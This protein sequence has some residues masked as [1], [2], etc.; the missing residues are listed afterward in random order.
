MVWSLVAQWMTARK[1]L[2]N[3]I[4]WLVINT[5]AVPL[6]ISRELRITAILYAGLWLLAVL[7]YIQWRRKLV[8]ASWTA[9]AGPPL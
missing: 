6:Y 5:V 7:G 9:T 2:E 3:W 1:W 4:L 8:V